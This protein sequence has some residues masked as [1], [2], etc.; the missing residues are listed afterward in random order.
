[1]AIQLGTIAAIGFEDIPAERHLPLFH[2]LGCTVVQAYRNAKA[3][4]SAAQM[5]EAL[6]SGSMPCDSLHGIF[7]EEYDP[8]A[9]LESA[10][11]FAVE[12]FKSEGRLCLELGGSLVVVHCS[13]IR[14]E[15]I[16]AHERLIRVDQL[17]RS[18]EDLGRY[19]QEAGLRYAFENLPSYHALGSD[20]AEL[21]GILRQV[22]APN[23]GMCFD[24]GHANMAGDVPAAV[25][26]GGEQIIYVHLSDNSGDAD[27]HEMITCGRIDAPAMARALREIRYSGTMMLE[28][29]HNE[30]RL[31]QIIADGCA[32]RLA[33]LVAIADGR[34]K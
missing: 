9:P 26:A 30:E 16:G 17:K 22:G 15:G 29:F 1:M 24:C 2:E 31:R 10:R 21:A 13:T 14:R 32:A 28:V 3:N 12:T 33:N 23:T 18:I 7:G 8:S 25:R 11:Q 34:I 19:G 27:E 4:I 5:R 6:A 20:V